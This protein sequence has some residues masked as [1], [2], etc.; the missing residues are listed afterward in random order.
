MV[1]GLDDVRVEGEPVAAR[2]RLELELVDVEAEAVEPVQALGELVA[3]VGAEGLVARQLA[4]ER[5]VAGDDLV[6]RLVGVE[7]RRQTDLGVDVEQLADNVRL[8]DVE[9]VGSLAVGELRV[10]L[11]GLRV[12]E[13]G[14]ERAGVAAEERVRERAVAPEEAAEME[15]REE[16]GERVQGVRAEI[17][18]RRAGE[19][20][21]VGQRVLEV[22]RDQDRVEVV[23]AVG[24]DPDRLD[25]RQLLALEPAQERPLASRGPLGRASLSA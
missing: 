16:L 23:A 20:R 13:V 8:R 4:P 19:E 21:A 7:V 5:G 11:A 14:G 25:D 22:P 6:S 10:Q 9:V 1:A 3:L 17:G 18:D 24:H 12:D 15:A 2:R